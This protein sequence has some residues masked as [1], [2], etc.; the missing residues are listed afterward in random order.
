[1]SV[2]I[3]ACSGR[4]KPAIS[5]QSHGRHWASFGDSNP[6]RI[7]MKC[8]TDSC[9]F[10]FIWFTLGWCVATLTRPGDLPGSANVQMSHWKVYV[11]FTRPNDQNGLEVVLCWEV[12]MPGCH[13][14]K[15]QM[16]ARQTS[17]THCRISLE[18]VRFV[19]SLVRTYG[20]TECRAQTAG[21]VWVCIRW[22]LMSPKSPHGSML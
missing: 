1:M 9:R 3:W 14:P 5:H 8:G 13:C 16:S 4:V 17:L 12:V 20:Q 18:L 11:C 7:K 10:W 21:S 15:R 22:A 2:F 19:C 6:D